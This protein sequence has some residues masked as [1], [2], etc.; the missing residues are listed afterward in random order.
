MKNK[1]LVVVAHADDEAIGCGGTLIK[2]REAGDEVRIIFMTDGVGARN[3]A[4]THQVKERLAAQK[5]CCQQLNI[6][7]FYNLDYPDNKMDSIALIDVVKSIEEVIRSY[8]PSI[9]YTHHGGD[10]NIDHQVVHRAV[11]T[12][13]R[14]LPNSTIDKIL[15]FEVNSSTEWSNENIGANFSP[16]YFVDISQELSEKEILLKHYQEEMHTYPHS[17]SIEAILNRNK[18]RGS[19]VGQEAAEAFILV[20][21]LIRKI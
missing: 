10:L 12:A 14:P 1:I 16:N 17:R 4:E 11:M 15:T 6:N 8:A 5:N 3:E 21:S 7:D 18:V 9:I 20:R 2:H 19:D 13:A